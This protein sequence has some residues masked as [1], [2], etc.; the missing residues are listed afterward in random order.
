M[1]A[2]WPPGQ[3]GLG[4]DP[5][6]ARNRAQQRRGTRIQC[7]P[8]YRARAGRIGYDPDK[9]LKGIREMCQ[10]NGYPNGYIYFLGGGVETASTVPST[11]DEM[12]LQSHQGVLRL[13]PVWPREMDAH[14]NHLRAYGA[15]LVSGELS[16]GAVKG[17]VIE[18]EKGR[19]CTLQNPWRGKAIALTR[20]GHAAE[21]LTGDTVTFKTTPGERI[22]IMPR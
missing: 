8:L 4:G 19:P 1:L 20:N 3:I 13:F 6:A 7:I 2:I 21:T 11:I 14:F 18:S 5:R 15:F 17:V 16:K 10:K 12:L 22:A 9:L